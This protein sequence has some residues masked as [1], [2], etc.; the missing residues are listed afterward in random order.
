MLLETTRQGYTGLFSRPDRKPPEELPQKIH[1]TRAKKTRD[2]ENP[3]S[4]VPFSVALTP[5][6]A[7]G[8]Y[9]ATAGLHHSPAEGH[10]LA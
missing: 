4:G 2:V 9:Y 5:H 1:P 10:L 6:E 8:S 7:P 3:T